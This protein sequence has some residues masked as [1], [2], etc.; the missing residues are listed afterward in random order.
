M[1]NSVKRLGAAVLS[2]VMMLTA[3]ATPLCD[4]L[5][6][7]SESVADVASAETYTYGDYDYYVR[8]DQTVFILAYTGKDKV[9]NIPEEIEGKKV[10]VIGHIAFLSNSIEI[11]NIPNTVTVLSYE[12]FFRCGNLREINIPESVSEIGGVPVTECPSVEKINV[13]EKITIIALLMAFYFQKT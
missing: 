1:I 3:V 2:T 8:D 4:N 10:G 11:V 9:V 5:P 6:I 12:C 7:V 13:S